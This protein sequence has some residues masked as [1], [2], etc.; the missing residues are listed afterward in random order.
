MPTQTSSTENILNY[1]V[2]SNGLHDCLQMISATI[3]EEQNFESKTKL[4]H[5]INPHSYVTALNTPDFSTVLH[6]ADWLVPDGIGIVLASKLNGGR[7]HDRITGYDIFNGVNELLN[8]QRKGSVFFLGSTE[9]T[10][11][12]I[13]QKMA[14]DYPFVKIAGTYSPPFK[15]SFSHEDNN[16]MLEA[17]NQTEADV[18]WIGMTSPKQDLW[19]YQHRKK[20]NVKFAAGIGAVFDFYIGNI[21]R[22]HFF[23][24]KTGL[25]WFP[26]LLQDPKRLWKRTVISAPIFIAHLVKQKIRY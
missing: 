24:Q 25:E 10:L 17:I 5:C 23:F 22:S 2:F 3:N 11:E 12:L 9:K 15:P 8:R 21:K 1:Q 4:L 19:L 6:Q 26:R 7:I 16:N 20:L 14:I 13:Q 18:L